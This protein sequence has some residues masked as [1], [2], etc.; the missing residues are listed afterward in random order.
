MYLESIC[1]EGQRLKKQ[2]NS[3]ISFLCCANNGDLWDIL[4]KPSFVL[5]VCFSLTLFITFCRLCFFFHLCLHVW[6]A[7]VRQA[8]YVCDSQRELKTLA[9]IAVSKQ[10]VQTHHSWCQ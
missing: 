4:Q 10:H 2:I 3:A 6:V 7:R 8:A 9:A 5:S 1:S